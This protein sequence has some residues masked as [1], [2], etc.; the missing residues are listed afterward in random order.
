MHYWPNTVDVEI[1][2]YAKLSKYYNKNNPPII[3]FAGNFMNVTD[4]KLLDY[5]TDQCRQFRFELAGLIKLTEQSEDYRLLRKILNKRNVSYV[6]FVEQDELP[7]IVM[8]WDVCIMIDKI[9]ER[10]SYHHHNKLYQY[11]ALGKPVVAQR[12]H[13]DYDKFSDVVLL[14]ETREDFSRNLHKGIQKSYDDSYK[15]RC[16]EIAG[17]NS[18]IIR[19]R[20]FLEI[21][22]HER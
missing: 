13:G 5:V 20:Q 22:R 1:W 15:E 3:G 19:A 7:K 16:V 18:S 6:G 11:L 17:Q 9:D 12:N 21:V 10:S 2:N 4:V 14:S 8:R